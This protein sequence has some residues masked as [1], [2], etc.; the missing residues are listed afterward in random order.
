MPLLPV[1]GLIDEFNVGPLIISRRTPPTRNI[2][3][4][5]VPATATNISVNPIAV[6]NVSGKDRTMLPEAIRELETIEVY[7]KIQVYSGNDGQ[8]PDVITYAGRTWVCSLTM[9][10][11]RQGG[12]FISY[13]TLEDQNI[14]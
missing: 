13:F 6:H 5:M 11:D 9:D 3:G 2:Y 8:A 14:P 1:A 4:E 10:F 12:V 7:T